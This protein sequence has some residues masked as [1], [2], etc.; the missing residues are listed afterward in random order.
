MSIPTPSSTIHIPDFKL[1]RTVSPPLSSVI[2]VTHKGK[3]NFVLGNWVC[4][5][6][7]LVG[8]LGAS[9]AL[10]QASTL[11]NRLRGTFRKIFWVRSD[12]VWGPQFRSDMVDDVERMFWKVLLKV[13]F[14]DLESRNK[15]HWWQFC[16]VFFQTQP[17]DKFWEQMANGCY[18]STSK[19]VPQI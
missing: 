19:W 10:N 8:A 5:V 2:N 14:S 16:G 15:F 7:D 3:L 11:T 9:V 4:L 17:N 6:S 1:I 18:Q 13:K 12:V